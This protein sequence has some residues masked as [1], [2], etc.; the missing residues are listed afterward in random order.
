[1]SQTVT[2]EAKV[3]QPVFIGPPGYSVTIWFRKSR[4]LPDTTGLRGN[5]PV[6]QFIQGEPSR[7]LADGDLAACSATYSFNSESGSLTRSCFTL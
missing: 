6:Q 5:R 1:M 2:R 3:V 7:R 4:M